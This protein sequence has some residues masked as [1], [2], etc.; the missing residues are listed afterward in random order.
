M[1]R[2]RIIDLQRRIEELVVMRDALARLHRHL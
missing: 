1:A 2:T